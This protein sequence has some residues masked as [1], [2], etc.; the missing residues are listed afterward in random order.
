MSIEVRDAFPGPIWADKQ[1]SIKFSRLPGINLR[2]KR[3]QT[4]GCTFER[5]SS[6][7]SLT[8]WCVPTSVHTAAL[9]IGGTATRLTATLIFSAVGSHGNEFSGQLG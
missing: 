2:N 8:C 5:Y 6:S 9:L 3:Y 7:L 4:S 1:I